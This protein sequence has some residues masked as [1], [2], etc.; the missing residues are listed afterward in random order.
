MIYHYQLHSMTIQSKYDIG[1]MV[2]LKTDSEQKIL[3]I[4]GILWRS[5]IQYE[6]SCGTD[7]RWHN[8]YEISE[9]KD[10][11]ISTTN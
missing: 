8:E 3:M 11:L 2:Y 4:T 1:Q 7:A 6:L 10:V 9:Q 5:G